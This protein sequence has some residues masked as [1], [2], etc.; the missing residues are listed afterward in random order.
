MRSAIDSG[1]LVMDNDYSSVRW[2]IP[3]DVLS[4]VHIESPP[5]PMFSSPEI[6]IVGP[7]SLEIPSIGLHLTGNVAF[8]NPTYG[9]VDTYVKIGSHPGTWLYG[10][11]RVIGYDDQK[12]TAEYSQRMQWHDGGQFEYAGGFGDQGLWFGPDRERP[13][14]TPPPVPTS[15]NPPRK[16]SPITI[17]LQCPVELSILDDTGNHIGY[18]STSGLIDEQIP[19]SWYMN[20]SEAQAA[21]ILDP[22]G[23]YGIATTG[24]AAGNYTL[25]IEYVTDTETTTQAFTGTISPQETKYYSAILSE[26]GQMT[27]ISWEYVFKD[28]KR[29]TML[30]ISTDDKYFQFT[31]PSK[32]FGVRHDPKMFVKYGI[33]VICYGDAEMRLTA[34]AIDSDFFYFCT[35][36]AYD[37]QTRKTYVLID[38]PYGPRCLRLYEQ[39]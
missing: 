23:D 37:K 1:Y 30:K 24:T 4:N 20:S 25:G 3:V 38:K 2:Q 9:S 29:G 10:I 39:L 26:T 6:V 32:D 27:A 5:T 11:N 18:N 12:S 34:T 14:V 17:Y 33:I 8:E 16:S 7:P 35:A 36:L 28:L 31:A 19:N 13:S 22:Q 21:V 15:S